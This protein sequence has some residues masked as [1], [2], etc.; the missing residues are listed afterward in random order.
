MSRRPAT[1]PFSA[2]GPS[3]SIPASLS[4]PI[5][6]QDLVPNSVP[7]TPSTATNSDYSLRRP[8]GDEDLTS[9]ATLSN[10]P[11]FYASP[12]V[13]DGSPRHSTAS[14]TSG[15]STQTPPHPRA[16]SGLYQHGLRRWI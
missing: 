15:D 6:T 10:Y 8:D 13:R 2:R 1:T 12:S 9:T 3:A 16:P 5:P 7:S 11:I 14:D 4:A